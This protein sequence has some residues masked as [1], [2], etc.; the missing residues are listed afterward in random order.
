L[1]YQI[2]TNDCDGAAEFFQGDTQM[3]V[4]TGDCGNLV[5]VACGDDIDFGG[6]N[7][8][9]NVFF[10][11]ELDETYYIM[12]D[13]YDYTAFN[14][15]PA[16]G[17]FCLNVVQVLTNVE[18]NDLLGLNAYPNPTSNVLNLNADLNLDYVRVYNMV[19]ALVMEQGFQTNNAQLNV[20]DLEAGIYVVE[21]TSGDLRSSIRFVKK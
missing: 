7:Y 4:Y 15:E 13:G 19:G 16:T 3:A 10:E 17:E 12:V 2:E 18:E 11:T 20:A 8:Y 9:S 5:P 14:A 21:I 1:N 6:G